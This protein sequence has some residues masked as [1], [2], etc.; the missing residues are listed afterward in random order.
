MPSFHAI[1]LYPFTRTTAQIFSAIDFTGEVPADEVILWFSAEDGIFKYK[2]HAGTVTTFGGTGDVTQAGDNVFTGENTFSGLTQFSVA[3]GTAVSVLVNG[4]D[5]LNINGSGIQLCQGGSG[6]IAC[7]A[8]LS[9]TGSLTATGNL[10]AGALVVAANSTFSTTFTCGTQSASLAYTLPVALPTLNRQALICTTAGVM[11]FGGPAL[12]SSTGTFS[13]T[14]AKTFSVSNTLTL[15]GTD[16][17]TLNIGAGGTLGSNA[18]TSTAYVPTSRTVNGQALTGDITVTAATIALTGPA[19]VDVAGDD[20]TGVVGDPAHPFQSNAGAWTA[21]AQFQILGQGSFSGV[22]GT[23][24]VNMSYWGMGNDNTSVTA[25]NAD[26]GDTSS[27]FH[28][29]DLGGKSVQFGTITY[30]GDG[31]DISGGTITTR[32]VIANVIEAKGTLAG[33]SGSNGGSVT[34]YDSEVI[35]VT[36]TPDSSGAG[37][38]GGTLAVFNSTLGAAALNA[39]GVTGNGGSISGKFSSIT[40]INITRGVSGT[41]GVIA[42]AFLNI[43]EVTGIGTVTASESRVG[44]TVYLGNF[45][46]SIVRIGDG[47]S[48]TKL[49]IMHSSGGFYGDVSLASLTANRTYTLP[50]VSGTLVTTANLD[51]IT[52]GTEVSVNS[53]TN[54]VIP[55]DSTGVDVIHIM[56]DLLQISGTDDVLLQLGTSSGIETTGYGGGCT[57]SS[58]TTNTSANSTGYKLN[59]SPMTSA[60]TISGVITLRRMNASN[61]WMM[62]YGGYRGGTPA[63]FNGSGGKTL[64]GPLTQVKILTSGSNTFTNSGT[65]NYLKE[66]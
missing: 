56:V 25:I 63:T 50:D 29:N 17:S 10:V 59:G 41:V 9:T 61:K 7:G 21:G 52:Q 44:S 16:G 1:P 54:T 48:A 62:T 65:A 6:T 3:S 33:S 57:T 45:A 49:R 27:H 30:N 32:G 11:S 28:L 46:S 4:D 40:A 55:I 58:T 26:S 51:T 14:N 38:N 12:T 35:Q 8:D 47:S 66:I 23:D 31:V 42:G 43:E 13:L 37:G 53:G 20:G 39:V 15:A 64:S 34:L 60:Y 36:A 18:F 5:M 24:G 22:S 2:D 19:W